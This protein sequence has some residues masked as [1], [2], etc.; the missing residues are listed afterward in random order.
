MANTENNATNIIARIELNPLL[1]HFRIVIR[2][3]FP[4]SITL[5]QD[6]TLTI[7]TSIVELREKYLL[8]DATAKSPKNGAK[9]TP[10]FQNQVGKELLTLA[11]YLT[12]SQLICNS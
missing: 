10:T 9:T 3:P 12:R 7:K 8:F 6:V 11:S 4:T 2:S 1:N 5:V